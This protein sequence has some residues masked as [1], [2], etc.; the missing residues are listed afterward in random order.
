MSN[1]IKLPR[2]VAQYVE[3]VNAGDVEGFLWAFAEDAV[4]E[5]VNRTIRGAD[6]IAKW[7]RR[8]IFGVEAR[9]EVMKLAASRDR[10]VV[11]VKIDGSFDRK[12]LPDP[13]L[14]DHAFVIAEGRISRL[15]IAFTEAT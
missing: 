4:V 11:T 7:A 3:T 5:D 6:A 10:T 1:E 13:L 2:P 9:L 8:E 12:G 14:M 15:E